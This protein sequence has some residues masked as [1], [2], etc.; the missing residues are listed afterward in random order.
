[1]HLFT[2]V[3][4][5]YMP[6]VGT[7]HG[8]ADQADKTPGLQVLTVWR[9]GGG[10]NWTDNKGQQSKRQERLRSPME[11]KQTGEG[12]VRKNGGTT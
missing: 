7:G 6:G 9:V 2:Y 4:T 8:A 3:S 5:Y 1:M 12:N 11:G 10:G